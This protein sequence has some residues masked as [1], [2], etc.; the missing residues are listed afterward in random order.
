[1]TLMNLSEAFI[2]HCLS[3]PPGSGLMQCHTPLRF[4]AFNFNAASTL[5]ASISTA[6]I[7]KKLVHF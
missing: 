1:M 4:S 2:Y 5:S 6:V 7:S 3:R